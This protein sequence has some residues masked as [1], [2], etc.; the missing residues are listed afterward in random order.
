MTPDSDL[1]HPKE[2]FRTRSFRATILEAVVSTSDQI[3]VMVLDDDSR[4]GMAIQ[5]NFADRFAVEHTLTAEP[6]LAR[7][8]EG[9]A[10]WDVCILDVFLTGDTV[11]GIDV[12]REL[13]RC[14]K[15]EVV[16]LSGANSARIAGECYK[17]GA[18]DYLTKPVALNVLSATIARAADHASRRRG[19]DGAAA[20][21]ADMIRIPSLLGASP[22][23]QELRRTI[24]KVGKSDTAVLIHGETGTG[25]ELVA[26]AVHKL[27][28]RRQRKFVPLNCGALADGTIDSALF[29]HVKGAFTG[30]LGEHPGAFVEADGGTLFLDEIGD[31]PLNSQTLL[32]RA[33]QGEVRPLGATS[34]TR[35]DVRL[36]SATHVDLQAAVR[37][38]RFREDLFY[39]LQVVPL[40]VPPL[41]KRAE[42]IPE[43]A[44]HFLKKHAHARTGDRPLPEFDRSTLE[45]LCNFSWPGNV[46]Q[47]ENAV[48]CA[49]ALCEGSTIYPDHLHPDITSA[50]RS[51]PLQVLTDLQH[52]SDE[53]EALPPIPDGPASPADDDDDDDDDDR[54]SEALLFGDRDHAHEGDELLGAPEQDEPGEIELAPGVTEFV[55]RA[56][57]QFR[58]DF[59]GKL[60]RSGALADGSVP[61]T[62]ILL[63]TMAEFREDYLD[64][65]M[66]PGEPPDGSM[67]LTE[68]LRGAMA[69]FR[70][71]YLV[72]LMRHT[73]GNVTQAAKIAGIDRPN[74][75]RMLRAHN[76]DPADY[77]PRR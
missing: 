60:A 30:A 53:A 29:G 43:L 3:R 39:R 21:E 40:M 48:L 64:K 62:E 15:T 69:Q 25:K 14:T 58:R 65:L 71:D 38:G 76:I 4:I 32:L 77:R 50:P 70:K 37:E 44:H 56:M 27:S 72:R 12:L 35:V 67:T 23:M 34:V 41:R 19:S 18:F 74:F 59:L 22:A 26:H 52:S 1:R 55:R 73:K 63:R 31:M 33:V 16:M 42:D 47:L 57:K 54:A 8:R 68:L 46:R 20:H 11:N 75:R 36:I 61:M 9:R 49:L 17:N 45:I 10:N 6:V 51:Q 13:R 24:E 66:P 7:V 5:R 2:S 28:E